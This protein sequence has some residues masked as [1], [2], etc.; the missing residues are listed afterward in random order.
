MMVCQYPIEAFSTIFLA[1]FCLG[2]YNLILPNKEK[3]VNTP[4]FKKDAATQIESNLKSNKRMEIKN[5][6]N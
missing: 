1:L 6:L 5:L 3:K 4:V 2:V